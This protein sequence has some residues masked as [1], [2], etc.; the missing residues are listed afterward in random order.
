MPAVDILE[1]AADAD[2]AADSGLNSGW[3]GHLSVAL[4]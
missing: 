3:G 2:P 1:K 4:R